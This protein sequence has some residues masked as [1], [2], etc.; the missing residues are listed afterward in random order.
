MKNIFESKLCINFQGKEAVLE[1]NGCRIEAFPSDHVDS[2][3]ALD[4]P[5]F[6]YWMNQIFGER[7]RLIMSVMLLSDISASQIRLL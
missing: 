2:F 7:A 5:K 6:F 4:N 3:R 1:L